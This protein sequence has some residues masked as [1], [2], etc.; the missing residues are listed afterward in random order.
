MPILGRRGQLVTIAMQGDFGKPRPA[1]IIQANQFDN[2]ATVALLPVT[3]TIIAAPLFRVTIE[4]STTNGLRQTSQIMVDKPLTVWRDKIG[5]LVGEVDKAT[6]VAVERCLA[7][8]L[9]IAK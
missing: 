5:K 6:M 7:I 9:G 3:S 1:L 8:F 4:P 2:H